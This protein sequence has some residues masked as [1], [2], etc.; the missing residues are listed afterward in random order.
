MEQT[1]KQQTIELIKNAKRIVVMGHQNPDGDA[2]GSTLALTLAL[3]KLGKDAKAV[4]ADAV[5]PTFQFLPSVGEI[6]SEISGAGNDFVITLDTS[7]VTVDKLGYKNHPEDH[8]LTIVVKTTAG[9]FT[10]EAVS[11]S[12]SGAPA[13][14]LIVLDTNDVERLGT[15]YE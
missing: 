4:L 9:Q 11:F 15:L 7:A 13:D 8:K 10:P 2:I 5:P 6:S 1:P 3:R 12:A 14:L